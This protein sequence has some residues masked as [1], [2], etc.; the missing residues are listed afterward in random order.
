METKAMYQ[1]PSTECQGDILMRASRRKGIGLCDIGVICG[2][3]IVTPSG[4]SRLASVASA[5]SC[6]SD[7]FASR[8]IA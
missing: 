8:P 7:L 3:W 2:E 1:G 6:R 5:P 4:R